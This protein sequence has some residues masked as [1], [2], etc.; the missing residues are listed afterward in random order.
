[1]A[2]PSSRRSS[3]KANPPKNPGQGLAPL[4]VATQLYDRYIR[5]VHPTD[6]L[7]DQVRQEWRDRR[8]QR[9]PFLSQEFVASVNLARRM[10][11][12]KY[13]DRCAREDLLAQQDEDL[14]TK[15]ESIGIPARAQDDVTLIDVMTGATRPLTRYRSIC[16][17]PSIAKRDRQAMLNELRYFQRTHRKH[18]KY[19]RLLVV[20][21]GVSIPLGSLSRAEQ[22]ASTLKTGDGFELRDAIKKLSR[23]ISRWAQ[24]ADQVYD[25]DVI[26]RGI[27]FTV[28]RRGA[29]NFLSVHL[30]A[31]VL[32]TPRRL[33]PETE[34]QKFLAG[35]RKQFDDCWWKDCG[36]LKDPNEALKYP[37]KPVSLDDL[38]AAQ[39]GWLFEQTF[40]LPMMQPMG[41]FRA[42]RNDMLWSV[43]TDAGGI[44]RR[45]Q[46]HKVRMVDY[47]GGPRLEIH[48]VRKRIGKRRDPHKIVR[49]DQPPKENVLLCITM[50]QRRFSPWASPCAL[51]KNYTPSPITVD[52]QGTLDDIDGRRRRLLPNWRM[53]GAPDPAIALAVG[54][55]QTAALEGDAGSVLPFIVHTRS[56]TAGTRSSRGPPTAVCATAADKWQQLG[57]DFSVDLSIRCIR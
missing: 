56:S 51:V 48:S 34:W 4:Y 42:W 8:A 39:V 45:R 50:P 10:D 47:P 33:L 28:E 14:A 31:N 40:G 20:T 5:G 3:Q 44:S 41:S 46:H 23:L 21:A 17:L 27:E 26:F 24:T 18:R 30:H 55:G 15:L 53:N 32:A 43:E 54:R 1:M 12:K 7:E 6:A 13:L 9:D 19:V 22:S 35:T 52:G 16:F 38:E 57:V 25:I 2:M 11:P 37:F 36:R 29:D 49:D